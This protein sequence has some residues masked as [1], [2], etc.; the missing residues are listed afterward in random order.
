M[1]TS[2]SPSSGTV[3]FDIIDGMAIRNIHLFS[4]DCFLS[5]I[6]RNTFIKL[7]VLFRP[8][9]TFFIFCC[10]FVNHELNSNQMDY[11]DLNYFF[12]LF[13]STIRWR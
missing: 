10:I 11:E 6:Y 7:I 13:I 12:Y 8:Q 1:V 5:I 2:I 4:E 9:G 3:I